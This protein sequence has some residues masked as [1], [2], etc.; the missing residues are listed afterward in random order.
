VW[1]TPEP[2]L[3]SLQL[4]CTSTKTC[5]QNSSLEQSHNGGFFKH[6]KNTQQ[7]DSAYS[8][9]KGS[10]AQLSS[11]DLQPAV[12][13]PCTEHTRLNHVSPNLGD[14]ITFTCL[15]PI[16][17]SNFHSI[18]CY[19]NQKKKEEERKKSRKGSN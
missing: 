15:S 17:T 2:T 16:K 10:A 1:H 7:H 3:L 14:V 5:L 8:Q 11:Q 19:R 18:R 6:K 13:L 12:S 9:N 4:I